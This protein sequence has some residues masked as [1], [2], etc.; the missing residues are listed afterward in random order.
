MFSLRVDTF[1]KYF[2]GFGVVAL[3]LYRTV[4]LHLR[5]AGSALGSQLALVAQRIDS[6]LKASIPHCEGVSLSLADG[7][8]AGQ[9]IPHAHL[10]VIPRLTEDDFGR[11]RYGSVQDRSE[12]DA[13]AARIRSVLAIDSETS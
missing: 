6:A 7:A 8:A 11:R 1:K 3:A 5:Q 9:E 2:S 4:A 10:H 13:I 12:L